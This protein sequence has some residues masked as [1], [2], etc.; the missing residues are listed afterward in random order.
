LSARGASDPAGVAFGFAQNIPM[1]SVIR[2]FVSTKICCYQ[3]S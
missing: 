3:F 1:A 2:L